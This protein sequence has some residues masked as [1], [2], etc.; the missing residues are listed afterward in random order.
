VNC[1]LSHTSSFTS[2]TKTDGT[3]RTRASWGPEPVRT[4]RRNKETLASTGVR[5]PDC[6]TR[7][8]VTR[9]TTLSLKTYTVNQQ[10][11]HLFGEKLP[12]CHP[13][14]APAHSGSLSGS[15]KNSKNHT[16]KKHLGGNISGLFPKYKCICVCFFFS[17]LDRQAPAQ[18]FARRWHDACRGNLTFHGGS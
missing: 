17:L 6:S 1:L 13:P 7:K 4:F 12:K 9:P 10:I 11:Y 16:G 15:T 8:L 14:H 18:R 5:I 2:R 3:H